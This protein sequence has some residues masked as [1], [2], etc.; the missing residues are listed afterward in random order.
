MNGL[1]A[2]ASKGA[3]A[4]VAALIAAQIMKNKEPAP[5]KDQERIK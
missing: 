3:G 5:G 2:A 4:T 1:T